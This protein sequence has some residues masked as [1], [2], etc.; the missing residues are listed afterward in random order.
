MKPLK[1][2]IEGINSFEKKVE[3]D[4]EELTKANLFGVFGETGSG[5]TTIIDSIM[6]ALYNSIPRYGGKHKDVNMIN[7]NLKEGYVCLE[8][9][10]V[11]KEIYTVTRHYKAKRDE[12]SEGNGRLQTIRSTLLLGD[13]IISDKEKGVTN[14]IE[15]LIGL[16]YEDFTKSVILPQGKFSEF[17]NLGDADKGKMLERIF[18]LEKYGDKFRDKIGS[19]KKNLEDKLTEVNIKKES[20][21]DVT[22]K[23]IG[24]HK[25][26]KKELEVQ[27]E[28]NDEKIKNVEKNKSDL[29]TK[30]EITKTLSSLRKSKKELDDKETEYTANVNAL[31]NNKNA[32]ILYPTVETVEKIER[33]IIDVESKIIKSEVIENEKNEILKNEKNLETFKAEKSIKIEQ[34][35]SNKAKYESFRVDIVQLE[36]MEK[37]RV[38]LREQY[39]KEIDKIKNIEKK[40]NI[41]VKEIELK[42]IELKNK[43]KEIN[44][45]GVEEKIDENNYLQLEKGQELESANK[46]LKIDIEELERE[47]FKKN[48]ERLEVEKEIKNISNI[49]YEDIINFLEVKQFTIHRSKIEKIEK[50]IDNIKI[51]LKNKKN[52][53]EK[54]AESILEI[55]NKIT[56]NKLA[57]I[58]KEL[59]SDIEKGHKCKVCGNAHIVESEKIVV[60]EEIEKK[61]LK[62]L[63]QDKQIVEEINSLNIEIATIENTLKNEKAKVIKSSI[64]KHEEKN[65]PESI[66]TIEEEDILKTIEEYENKKN[67][68]NTKNSIFLETRK[69]VLKEKEN[70]QKKIEDKNKSLEE[71]IKKIN[72]IK[73]VNGIEENIT[74]TA[75]KKSLEKREKLLNKVKL[76]LSV[77]E[78]DI[79]TIERENSKNIIEKNDIENIKNNIYQEGIRIKQLIDK[80]KEKIGK[81]NNIDELDKEILKC[82]NEIEEIK[83]EEKELID[84]L[85]KR[86]EILLEKEKNNLEKNTILVKL[87]NDLKEGKN[88]LISSMKK[89]S[90][91]N[92]EQIKKFIL[93]ENSV[94]KLEDYVKNYESEKLRIE[95]EL[96]VVEKNEPKESEEQLLEKELKIRE[97]LIYKS[98]YRDKLIK[99]EERIKNQIIEMEEKYEKIIKLKEDGKVLE[100]ELE[101]VKK[102]YDMFKGKKFVNFI[103][104]RELEKIVLYASQ[105]L[106]K[107]TN[108]KYSLETSDGEFL[109]LDNFNGGQRRS[110]K[111][112]SGGEVFITSLCLS[113]AISRTVQLKNKGVLDF[114]FLDEGFGSLDKNSLDKVMGALNELQKENYKIGIISHVEELKELV[115]KKLIVEKT[116]EGSKIYIE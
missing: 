41:I 96:T 1:L 57:G 27:K 29:I 80:I 36:P 102:L 69:N 106:N 32:K 6:L 104:Q 111:T 90:F 92:V 19:R 10:T 72:D 116:S 97:D 60:D 53:R 85:A 61:H 35:I 56:E 8:F 45:L 55:E 49:N 39:G 16:N 113:L 78:K 77:I 30:I 34:L 33:E 13:K 54:L 115:E 50:D 24:E 75:Y 47:I 114:F 46:N 101:V 73:N 15:D 17:L 112:L 20:L 79:N 109:I 100:S 26:L 74:I 65:V 40:I 12:D 107:M 62:E 31:N 23:I 63:E 59:R 64:K 110:T 51:I 7:T 37:E 58:V 87:N 25:K 11:G 95:K 28:E 66:V 67:E 52:E 108:G 42:K 83:K 81:I 68:S 89:Y 103:S 94:S 38:H 88:E 43:N 44:E 48:G 98:G 22:K 82:S 3:I 93:D 5:K 84:N 18:K 76:E 21:G 91:G 70:I 2:T 71:S 4:F 9:S 99:N 105:R 14:Y 86:K